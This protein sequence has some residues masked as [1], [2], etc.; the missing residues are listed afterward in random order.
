MQAFRLKIEEVKCQT[1]YQ[2]LLLKMK[3]VSPTHYLQYMTKGRVRGSKI[4]KQS[5]YNRVNVNRD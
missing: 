1:F 3:G 4:T 5:E 2:L